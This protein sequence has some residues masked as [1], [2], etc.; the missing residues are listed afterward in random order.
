MRGVDWTNGNANM[1]IEKTTMTMPSRV[2]RALKPELNSL[3]SI[4]TVIRAN[5]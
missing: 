2:I 1:I 5:P 3:D 4:P